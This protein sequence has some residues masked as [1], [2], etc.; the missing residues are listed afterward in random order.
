MLSK[1]FPKDIYGIIYS[2]TINPKSMR[3][4]RHEFFKEFT[5]LPKANCLRV[6][7]TLTTLNDRE[8]T[9]AAHPIQRNGQIAYSIKQFNER[10]QKIS[11]GKLSCILCPKRYVYS[12]LSSDL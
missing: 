7:K 1:I 3:L 11:S 5:W 8:M 12:V 10:R 2:Y 6:N 9:G 4:L